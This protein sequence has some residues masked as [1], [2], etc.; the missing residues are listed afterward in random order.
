MSLSHKL[1]ITDT[2]SDLI[3]VAKRAA[4]GTFFF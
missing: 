2:C 1:I 3:V 4:H